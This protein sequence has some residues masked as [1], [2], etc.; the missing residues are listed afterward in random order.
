M[1]RIAALYNDEV[2]GAN[3]LQQE[4]FDQSV[5][6]A[7]PVAGQLQNSISESIEAHLGKYF[8]EFEGNL[9]P[10]GLYDRILK[11]VEEPLIKLSL[12]M[13]NGNQIRTAE[14]LGLNRNTLRKKIRELGIDVV[15][16]PK[17]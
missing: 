16:Q 10:A 13:T 12:A 2:I 9:P 5:V 17:R 14:M 3:I 11:E 6:D 1:R 15:R 7:P 4:L 8:N